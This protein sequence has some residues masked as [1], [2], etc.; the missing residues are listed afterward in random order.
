L[1]LQVTVDLQLLNTQQQQVPTAHL[2]IQST[3]HCN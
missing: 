1:H 2:S 3:Q